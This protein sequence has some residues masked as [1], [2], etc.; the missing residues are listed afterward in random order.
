MLNLLQN[1]NPVKAQIG[2]AMVYC[3]DHSDA[4]QEVID[5]IYES[6][7]SLDSPFQRKIAQLFLVSDVL[8][9]CS[10]AVTNASFYRK[11]FQQKLVSIYEHLRQ[12]L[13]NIEDRHRAES[14]KQKALSVLGAWREWTLY[15]DEFVI[16]LSNILLGIQDGRGVQNLPGSAQATDVPDGPTEPT[17]VKSSVAEMSTMAAKIGEGLDGEMLDEATLS[18]CL[19]AKGLSM[20]WYKTLE[21]SDD[22]GEGDLSG[23]E[24]RG[25]GATGS[26]M[27]ARGHSSAK[28]MVGADRIKFKTSKWETVD[29]NEV[30]E[31]AVSLTKWQR[32]VS[33]EHSPCDDSSG[34]T[35]SSSESGSP[36]QKR[37]RRASR[38][39]PSN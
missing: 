16:Q 17:V 11:G 20:R 10:A 5:C 37:P 1:L 21:L 27:S 13:V 24:G 6:L 4:A 38:S 22:E 18:Q 33:G 26:P 32:V 15:E 3:I 7:C 35:D 25:R 19:E 28:D 2:S 14:F 9:N 31:Q 39:P 34:V 8:H 30:A 29:P 36:R 23:C 12:Y